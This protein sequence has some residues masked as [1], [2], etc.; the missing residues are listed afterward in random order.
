MAQLKTNLR[1]WRYRRDRQRRVDTDDQPQ[2]PPPREALPYPAAAP[3]SR[4]SVGRVAASRQVGSR[5]VRRYANHMLACV[6]VGVPTRALPGI[7]AEDRTDLRGRNEPKR[8]AGRQR[9]IAR[10]LPTALLLRS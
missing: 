9:E 5:G 1:Y 4:A 8:E 6:E 3:M 2:S 10:A 7:A